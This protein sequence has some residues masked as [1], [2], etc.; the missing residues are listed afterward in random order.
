[1]EADGVIMGKP[2]NVET[3]VRKGEPIERA[4]R[5]FLRRVKKDKIMEEVI[6]RRFYEKPSQVR[7]RKRLKIKR[8]IEQ[9]N[10]KMREEE[11]R[12]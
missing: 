6:E 11:K 12:G 2:I 1:M 10:K 8:I 9:N 3:Y 4:I 5:R 7:H